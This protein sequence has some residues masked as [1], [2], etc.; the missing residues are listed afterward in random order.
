[1]KIPLLTL[2]S[3]TTHTGSDVGDDGARTFASVV[4][5]NSSIGSL[6]LGSN[7]I[8]AEGAKALATVLKTNKSI[9]QLDLSG[10]RIG[11]EGAESF[12]S[13]ILVNKALSQ[14]VLTD[15]NVS[16]T[17][18]NEIQEKDKKKVIELAKLFR[19]YSA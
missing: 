13:T 4:V 16:E 12:V 18:R 6:D 1:L 7:K 17:K 19:R 14:I 2:L 3:Q 11:D 9:T 5:A 15:N 8:T 10:N